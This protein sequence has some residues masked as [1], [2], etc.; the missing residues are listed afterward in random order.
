[1]RCAA[2]ARAPA[3][4]G[5][6]GT[7]RLATRGGAIQLDPSETLVL[8]TVGRGGTGGTGSP[9]IE[10][11]YGTPGGPGGAG[12]E[13]NGGTVVLDVIGGTIAFGE[14]PPADVRLDVSG[15]GGGGGQGAAVLPERAQ[16]P[17]VHAAAAGLAAA[18]RSGSRLPTSRTLPARW[19]RPG[20]WS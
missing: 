16:G 12:G 17:L 20:A 8:S 9:P 5:S 7:V 10:I 19:L 14:G 6:A 4:P 15:Y 3:V 2:A 11:G 13:G 1:M 18:A